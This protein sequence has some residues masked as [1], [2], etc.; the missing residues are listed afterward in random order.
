LIFS[1]NT[2]RETVAYRSFQYLEF[3]VR[4]VRKVT[5]GMLAV[6]LLWEAECRRPKGMLGGDASASV[7]ALAA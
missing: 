2:N 7:M 5:T 3:E 4:G 1:T 6:A